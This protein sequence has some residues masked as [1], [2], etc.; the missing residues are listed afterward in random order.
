MWKFS[1][2]NMACSIIFRET[3]ELIKK[4]GGLWHF[5]LFV[6]TLILVL[7]AKEHVTGPIARVNTGLFIF[8]VLYLIIHNSI[9]S[10]VKRLNFLKFN[11]MKQM[12]KAITILTFPVV[13]VLHMWLPIHRKISCTLRFWYPTEYDP[14]KEY[15]PYMSITLAL[16]FTILV[17]VRK[18]DE[19]REAK[20]TT[21]QPVMVTRSHDVT[22]Q[23]PIL[24]T[25]D[26]TTSRILRSSNRR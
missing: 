3:V 26:P 10:S 25:E 14:S 12:A 7:L 23:K 9:L 4:F 21:P 17:I 2:V 16:L 24:K 1:I 8:A 5:C 22:P 11:K 6:W 13:M 20:T 18:R 15:C 19:A